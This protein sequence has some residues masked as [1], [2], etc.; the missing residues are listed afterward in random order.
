MALNLGPRPRAPGIAA[1][2]G[3]ALGIESLMSS[4]SHHPSI[5]FLRPF[6]PSLLLS[7]PFSLSLLSSPPTFTFNRAW[8]MAYQLLC[9]YVDTVAKVFL[10][11]GS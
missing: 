5:T 10:V 9:M 11:K 1:C 3:A 4:A 6:S 7:P 8:G 2:L